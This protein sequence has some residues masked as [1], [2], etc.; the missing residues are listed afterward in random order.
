VLLPGRARSALPADGTIDGQSFLPQLCGQPGDPR[1]AIYCWYFRNGKPV[2]G[3]KQHKAGESART[4]RYKLYLRD[5]FYDVAADFLEQQPLDPASLNASQRQVRD[6]L[7]GVLET[8]TRDGFYE[9]SVD[10]RGR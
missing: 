8:Y 10:G 2:S 1:Q 6:R 4:E 7:Q 3:G 9:G 5:G